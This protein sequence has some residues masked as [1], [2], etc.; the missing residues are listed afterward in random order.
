G[1]AQ[2]VRLDQRA[3]HEAGIQKLRHHRH[4]APLRL[5]LQHPAPAQDDPDGDEEENRRD[6]AEQREVS[7]HARPI[8]AI[9]AP[10]SN[11]ELP[12][13]P[14]LIFLLILLL[15]LLSIKAAD[16]ARARSRSKD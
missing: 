13:P 6:Q 3:R 4:D 15:I 16:W 14:D 8:D 9:R 1:V 11:R 7:D 5:R 2:R 12:P 10:E